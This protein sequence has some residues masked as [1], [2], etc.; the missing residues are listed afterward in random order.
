MTLLCNKFTSLQMNEGDDF[1]LH[2][3]VSVIDQVPANTNP[4]GNQLC[5]NILSCLLTEWHQCKAAGTT[6]QNSQS[7]FWTNNCYNNNNQP[8]KDCLNVKCNNCGI[9]G[10][11]KPECCKPGGGTYKGGNNNFNCNNNNKGNFNCGRGNNNYRGR[12]RGNFRYNNNCQNQT[13]NQSSN[14][15]SSS[16]QANFSK[17]SSTYNPEIAFAFCQPN[18]PELNFKEF[19]SSVIG[20]GG[21]AE[22]EGMGK[23]TLHISPVEPQNVNQK[24]QWITAPKY[25]PDQVTLKNVALVPE[26]PVNLISLLAQTDQFPKD[27]ITTSKDH[28]SFE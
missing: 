21:H 4:D 28:M 15:G 18:A 2:I 17:E 20:I 6:G 11:I 14:S 25:N 8:P 10:H 7:S 24:I 23:V 22:I 16:Q 3:L 27:K 13:S 12:G 19:Y 1:N 26:S 9:L 5:Q